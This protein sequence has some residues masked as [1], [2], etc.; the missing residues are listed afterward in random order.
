MLE[1][2]HGLPELRVFDRAGAGRD[3]LEHYIGGVF[4]AAYGA[5]VSGFMPLLAGLYG[6][7]EPEAALGLRSAARQSLFCEQY[8]ERPVEHFTR[9]LY[10]V[11]VRRSQVMELGNLAVSRGGHSGILYLL[12]A[13][14][15]R[16]ADV[17]FLL[18][19]GNKAVRRS[20]AR[21]G[22]SPR[23]IQAAR[24]ECLPDGGRCWGSYY[25]SEPVVM[26]ADIRRIVRQAGT[27]PGMVALMA[28][29]AGA[30][31]SLA[32]AVAREAA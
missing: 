9:S 28:H 1:T 26:L 31:D 7:A 14:A 19:A 13:C 32:A 24:P 16:A 11:T 17:D 15:L 8:L 25:A 4:A 21:C 18:F 20:I 27:Q 29:Y 3:Q 30:I 23:P 22:F 5:A 2:N 12:V 6:G 10:G